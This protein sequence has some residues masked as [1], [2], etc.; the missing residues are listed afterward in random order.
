[1][2]MKNFTR[3]MFPGFVTLSLLLFAAAGVYAQFNLGAITGRVTDP[4]GAVTPQCKI[5]VQDTDTNATRSTIA[6]NDGVYTLPS[7]PAG[8]YKVS[9][10]L[11][12]FKQETA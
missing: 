5:E 3:S 6:N 10:S 8:N 11:H 9:A 12:G 7:L 4:A 1:M 2:E